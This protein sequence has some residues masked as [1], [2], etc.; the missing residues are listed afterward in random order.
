MR[1]SGMAC[2]NGSP[3]G[4]VTHDQS[5]V[6]HFDQRQE[7]RRRTRHS[8][9]AAAAEFKR[10]KAIMGVFDEGCMGMF[11]AIIPDELLNRD[12]RLQGAP[13]P[14]LPLR[15]HAAG[16]RRRG[17]P[18]AGLAAARKG[19]KFNW[20][21]SEETELTRVPNLA[22]VQN[23]HRGPPHRRRFRLR[24]HRH[25]ISAGPEGPRPGQRFGRGRCSTTS[26]A[27]RS[28]P[29]KP[30]ASLSRAK[31]LP[32]FNEVD[33]CAGLDGLIT[34][35]LWTQLGFAPENTLHDIRWGQHVQRQ[36]RE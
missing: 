28:S 14:V 11:N 13:Q 15:R 24:R 6:R 8:A 26:T 1:F 9:G 19:M 3:R 33:E 29:R 23:V 34:Y 4:V 22:T 21:T 16:P 36:R 25:P 18:G 32:H 20:G 7:S 31:P 17:R 35:R 30:D 10:R 5:H 2:A 12:R 27:R